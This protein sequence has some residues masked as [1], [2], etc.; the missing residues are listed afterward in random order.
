[1]SPHQSVP[2]QIIKH[3]MESNFNIATWNLCLGL[4]NKKDSVT[5]YLTANNIKA[6][7][8]QETEIPNGFPENILNCG[9]YNVE[10]ELNTSKKRVGIYIQKEVVYTR[11]LDL[12][13]ENHHIVI[14][15]IK[16]RLV[17]CAK[18]SVK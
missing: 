12:E 4:A 5:D 9:N 10:L 6:C 13:K 17:Y 8:L 3:K 14:I 1:M 18:S 16:Y 2:G 15:D 11:R 7:C